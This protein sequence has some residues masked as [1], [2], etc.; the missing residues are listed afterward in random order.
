ML[1]PKIPSCLHLKLLPQKEKNIVAICGTARPVIAGL[2]LAICSQC[3]AWEEALGDFAEGIFFTSQQIITIC[4]N[5]QRMKCGLAISFLLR[6]LKIENLIS[7]SMLISLITGI[8]G[9]L[10]C[11][12]TWL[13]VNILVE[14]ME[15]QCI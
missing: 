13:L 1:L 8:A 5:A 9:E 10:I 3:G 14:G 7:E 11:A 15:L 6:L 2:M 4:N 12:D